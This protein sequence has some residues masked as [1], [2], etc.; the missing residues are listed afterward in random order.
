MTL[1]FSR[2][3]VSQTV[4]EEFQRALTE[5]QN[6]RYWLVGLL[7]ES[8]PS[9]M[10]T[11]QLIQQ[12][13]EETDRKIEAYREETDR[14]IA[15][16]REETD[17]RIAAIREETNREIAAFREEMAAHREKT[18]QQMAAFREEMAALR[19]EFQQ[20]L[21]RI[22]ATLGALGARWG[23]MAE[24]AFRDGM[25]GILKQRLGWKVERFLA[26]DTE[27]FVF[28]HPDQV[29]IDVVIHDGFHWL[30]EVRSS[31]SISDMYTFAR[32]VA[33]Y[34]KLRGVRA[35]RRIV[36]SPMVHPHARDVAQ[37]LGIEVYTSAY[38][39]S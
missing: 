39:V 18:D 8:F 12:M 13:R 4:L 25:A 36:V 9:R 2:A 19:R 38:D 11:H 27:G 14:Q 35:E 20:G 7:N 3:E 5:D 32:K 1:T 6:F 30:V 21:N 28:G 15:A 29:E 26:K 34:E 22:E 10:E 24:D 23:M 31:V 37:K 17:R 16:L 33:F